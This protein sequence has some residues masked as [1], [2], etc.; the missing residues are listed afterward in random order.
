VKRRRQRV[1][2]STATISTAEAP[3]DVWGIDFQ[4]DS[5]EAGRAI[6]I[7]SVI[8][9]H[10]REALGGLVERSIT[11]PALTAELDRIAAA[12]GL[13]KVI[14]CDNG[15]EFVSQALATWAD[16]QVSLAYIPPGKPWRNGYIESFNGRL[17]DECLNINS[18]YSLR[19]ARVIIADWKHDY[20]HRR[21]HSALG[22]LAPIQYAQTCTHQTPDDSHS[23]RT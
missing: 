8:D 5:D 10:T 2:E 23:D 18:F 3:N 17:R 20:N 4:F 16:D 15:P 9:E 21:R 12:R 22:Y 7:A 19:H 14:R 13:P 1:G 11:A 6:K